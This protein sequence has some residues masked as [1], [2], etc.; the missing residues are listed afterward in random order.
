MRL[1]MV[2]RSFAEPAVLDDVQAIEDAA[3]WCLE[4]NR[5]TFLHTYFSL[6][7]RRMLCL[8]AGPDAEAVRRAQATAKMPF[9]RVWA[10]RLYLPDGEPS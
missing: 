6:D 7:R 1:V 3:A 8:Y 5:V 2:E 4:T 10:A 9:D